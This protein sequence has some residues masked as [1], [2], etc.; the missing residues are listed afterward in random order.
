MTK[1]SLLL[2][3]LGLSLSACS[4]K[5]DLLR[6]SQLIEKAEE[7]SD[8]GKYKDAQP[9]VEEAL[10]IRREELGPEHADTAEALND[11]AALYYHQ[12]DYPR[13]EKLYER[14]LKIQKAALG[15]EHHLVA[16]TQNNLA[17]LLM[18]LGRLDR[19][20]ELFFMALM[21]REKTLGKEHEDVANTLNNLCTLFMYRGNFQSARPL[22]ERAIKIHEKVL[23]PGDPDL[24]Y[25]LNNLAMV[26]QG[27]G[28]YHNARSLLQ[29]ALELREKALGPKHPLVALSLNNLGMWHWRMG[30][31]ALARPLYERSAEVTKISLGAD[32]PDYGTSLNNLATLLDD[33]GDYTRART[34][35][36]Q[37]LSI[38]E[39][40]LGPEHLNVAAAVNNLALL[41]QTMGDYGLAEKL[42]LRSLEIK[43]KV[44][45]QKHPDYL[46]SLMNLGI[47]QQ[48]LGDY[49]EARRLLEIALQ[50]REETRGSDHPDVASSMV[51]LARVYL[52]LREQEKAEKLY[53][54]A[55]QIWE[56]VLGPDHLHLA[57]I[58]NDLGLI[59]FNQKK[60]DQAKALVNR[61]FEI[62]KKTFG[63]GHPAVMLNRINVVY[64]Y[65]ALGDA[66]AARK[67]MRQ[68]FEYIQANILPLLEA[69]SERER[70]ALILSQRGYLNTYLSL[71]SR[72]QDAA[73]A[74]RAVL[75][76]KG[77]VANTLAAQRAAVLA[78][79]EPEL[80]EAFE[81]LQRLRRTL[82]KVVF[83][84]PPGGDRQRWNQW[85]ESL[86]RQKDEL[87]RQLAQKSRA[88]AKKKILSEAGIEEICKQLKP[89]QA[90]IDYLE[91]ELL[92]PDDPKD[93]E[94][95]RR[96]WKFTAFLL[97]GGD[98]ASPVRV[99]IGDSKPIDEAVEHYRRLVTQST[100]VDRKNRAAKN[101]KELI[102]DPLAEKLGKRKHVW[103]VP[104]G[105]LNSVPF[106]ALVG[107]DGNYLIEEYTFGYLSS[108]LDLVRLAQ[109]E[110]KTRGALIAGGIDYAQAE[111]ASKAP[112]ATGSRAP[113][114][115]SGI[116]P[117]EALPGSRAE[118]EKV[119]ELLS[120][121]KI[122]PVA[123]LS[124]SKASER[125]IKLQSSGKRFLHLA[126]HGFFATGKVRSALAG[127]RGGGLDA[128][129][130]GFNPMLL[131]GV[132]LAGANA[133]ADLGGATEDGVL[134][135]LEVA[136]LD[137]RGTELV[138]LSACETGL[139]E[140]VTGEGVMGLR[141]AFA[142]AGARALLL[143][144]WKIPDEETRALME[145]FYRQV[146]SDPD[147]DKAQALRAAQLKMISKAKEKLDPRTWAAFILSGR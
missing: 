48:Y 131:S 106:C 125:Q 108:S 128:R 134:T 144:L 77:V 7:L 140:L 65:W 101:L 135:A 27:L 50:L 126:T 66:D 32:H 110:V 105:S 68:T 109:P 94:G 98:C 49:D 133:G 112:G 25:S 120:K 22:A 81:Q 36:E 58:L 87:E 26:L 57:D 115:E 136:G 143:S 122:G 119:A 43:E 86:N 44:V 138:T 127:S 141:R 99:E 21:I 102:W 19:A 41:L 37:S 92:V 91:Y 54:R 96:R 95:S 4:A 111:D 59:R 3:A 78:S 84:V 117:L 15:P 124:G 80:K 14:A 16:Q 89:G 46:T 52:R 34:L 74:Y 93:L 62:K 38:M 42:L 114:V 142:E 12:A 73:L 53:E 72:Q 29:R 100:S 40:K 5:Q 79:R 20:Q 64:M 97:L 130:G 69:T 56:K 71:F 60:K 28:D 51:N 137:L 145:E 23:K 33:M 63:E 118:A 75:G 76:W 10:K 90:V 17:A 129:T 139:G 85:I 6:A 103:I 13:A 107:K 24:A 83:A 123:V 61:A 30:E 1:P 67:E 113:K 11:L 70:I 2:L 82:A 104:D 121:G 47:L 146:A 9:L 55:L 35:L 45:G 31:Y 132:V 147:I 116:F 88:F 39:A 18:D 8:N